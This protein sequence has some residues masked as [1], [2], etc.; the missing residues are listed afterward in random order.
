MEFLIE[1]WDQSFSTVALIT[2]LCSVGIFA[3]IQTLGNQILGALLYPISITAS[4]CMS[5]LFTDHHFY[6]HRAFDKW[7]LFSIFSS[8]IG[9]ALALIAYIVLSRLLGLM[10]VAPKPAE[11]NDLRVRRIQLDAA[12]H[13]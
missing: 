12:R 9:M 13:P 3:V 8:A 1:A 5:K 7:V 2:I 11:L 4:L 6:S 10:R